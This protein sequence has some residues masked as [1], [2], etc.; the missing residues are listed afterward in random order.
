MSKPFKDT[1][2]LEGQDAVNFFN[3]LIDSFSE[4]KTPEQLAEEEQER[5]KMDEAYSFFMS[6]SDDTV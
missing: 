5:K 4:D 2:T 6:I 3:Y 1:P